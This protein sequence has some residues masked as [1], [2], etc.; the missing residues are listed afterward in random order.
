AVVAAIDAVADQRPQLLGDGALVLD[1]EIRNAAP[2]IELVGSADRLRRANIDAALTTSTGI[3][4]FLIDGKRKVAVDLAEKEPGARIAAEQHR[5][6][7][8]PAEAGARGELDLHHRR[9]IA[10]NTVTEGANLGADAVAEL[11]QAVTQHLVIVAAPGIARD[12]G[13]ASLRRDAL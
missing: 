5:V 1:G 10:E 4:L 6:L 11:L 8:A 12:D 13:P 3:L 2:R 7:A 9:R